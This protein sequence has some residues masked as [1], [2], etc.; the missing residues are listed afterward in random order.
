MQ[1]EEDVDVLEELLDFL[2]PELQTKVITFKRPQR[3][4]IALFSSLLVRWIFDQKGLLN[5]SPFTYAYGKHGKPFIEDLPEVKFNVSHSGQW[6]VCAVS[7]DE[8]GIDIEKEESIDMNAISHILSEEEKTKIQAT[9]P[10][11]RTSLFYGIWTVKESYL[12][13]LGGGL[14]EEIDLKNLSVQFKDDQPILKLGT[15]KIVNWN[16]YRFVIESN[17]SMTVCCRSKN[18][19]KGVTFVKIDDI[20]KDTLSSKV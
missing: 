13:A 14:Y 11:L 19:K 1:I 10:D 6:V 12:K 15:E 4:L 16:F 18:F 7:T 3:K 9:N 8:I 5:K 20:I 2:G 17:Y